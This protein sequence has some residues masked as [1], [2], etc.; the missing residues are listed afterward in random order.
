M[1]TGTVEGRA[2]TPAILELRQYLLRQGRRDD[3]IDL[4]ER[5]FVETQ[6]ACGIQ[7]V[8]QFRDVDRS[9]HFVWLRGFPDRTE[10]ATSLAAFYGG[11]VWRRFGEAANATMIDSDDVLMLRPHPASGHDLQMA[12]RDDRAG[13]S[14][15][16]VFVVIAHRRTGEE[17]EYDDRVLPALDRLAGRAGLTARGTYETDPAPNTYPALPIRR[18]N[19]VVWFGSSRTAQSVDLVAEHFVAVRSE[20][21]ARCATDGRGEI[22]MELRRLVPT[23]RSRIR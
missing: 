8:G 3:L 16:G 4:F 9:N 2:A 18:A 5:E 12:P 20:L 15:L 22:L 7:V 6:E 17:A 1:E 14:D 10:R 23:V 13:G 21:A 11:P 19:C